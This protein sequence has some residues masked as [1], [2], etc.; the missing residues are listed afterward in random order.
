MAGNFMGT[1]EEAEVARLLR[2]A[3]IAKLERNKDKWNLPPVQPGWLRGFVIDLRRFEVPCEFGMLQIIDF[4]L[5]E[6]LRGPGVP[7]RM[8][9]TYFSNRLRE[10]NVLDV[11]D[12]TPSV[13]PIETS[14]ATFSRSGGAIKLRAFYPGRGD[15]PRRRNLMLGVL[16]LAVPA[17]CFVGVI[18][19]L[20]YYFRIF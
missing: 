10:G 2:Q 19:M 1:R 7:V 16:G 3:E 5:S 18:A 12:E 20:H 14:L 9:G 17:I 15:P 4:E 13:R 8:T 11:R 6:T